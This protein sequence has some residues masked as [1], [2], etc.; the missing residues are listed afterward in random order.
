MSNPTK[1]LATKL[2]W[3]SVLRALNV[4][5][6][7][8]AYL[9]QAVDCT[10]CSEPTLDVMEDHVLGGVW[11]HCR[12]CKFSG[13]AVELAAETWT[14]DVDAAITQL[15][16]LG[17]FP[18]P[19]SDDDVSAYL[20]D[21]VR[22]RK[23]FTDFWERARREPQGGTD[24]DRQLL[25]KFCLENSWQEGWLEQG[26]QFFGVASKSALEELFAPDSFAIQERANR[27]DKKSKRRGPGPGP[28]RILDGH[29]W[30]HLIVVPF[31]DLPGRISGLLM[32]GRNG[33]FDAND[34]VFKRA[35]LGYSSTSPKEAGLG[36]LFSDDCGRA[37]GLGDDVFVMSHAQIGMRL[38]GKH[39]VDSRLPLPVVLVHE[40]HDHT[41][42]HL[43]P[44]LQERRLVFWG[45]MATMLPLAKRHGGCVSD[46]VI[47]ETEIDC[48]LKHNMPIDW[49]RL[50]RQHAK[51]WC[52][53][54]QDYAKT[55]SDLRLGNLLGKLDLTPDESRDLISGLRPDS[56]DQF[57]K[58]EPFRLSLRTVQAKGREVIESEAGWRLKSG[59]VICDKPIRVEYVLTTDNSDSVYRVAVPRGDEQ[60]TFV[61]RERDMKRDGLFVCVSR[62]LRNETGDV[63][64]YQRSWNKDALFI[65]MRF[66]PPETITSSHR[67]GWQMK[68]LRF[69]FPHFSILN[70]GQVQKEPVAIVLDDDDP[71]AQNLN[72]PG[73][74][75]LAH[76]RALSEPSSATQIVWALAACVCHNLLAGTAMPRPCGII[77]DG[78]FAQEAGATAARALGCAECDTTRRRGGKTILSVIVDAAARHAWPPLVKFRQ[79]SQHCF[80]SQWLDEPHL[81]NAILPLDEF[82]ALAVGSHDDF[83]RVC[84]PDPALPLGE[85]RLAAT[86]IVPNYLQDLCVRHKWIEFS[87]GPKVIDV[88]H[89][90][91]E[92]FRRIGGSSASVLNAESALFFDSVQRATT[93]A[94]LATRMHL[95]GEITTARAGFD[96]DWAGAKPAALIYCDADGDKP[97]MVAVRPHEINAVL[98][99]RRAPAMDLE[100]IQSAFQEASAWVGNASDDHG[101]LWLIDAEWWEEKTVELKRQSVAVYEAS[102]RDALLSPT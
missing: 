47:S 14:I 8:P 20:R 34:F 3:E 93:F 9:P 44:S 96:V 11:F 77:L 24:C 69:Q 15:D 26:G 29:G 74:F 102:K 27:N 100:R 4:E 52:C 66:S 61:I 89:D 31:H 62:S 21:H 83:V 85:L 13:D 18:D 75:P 79:R 6:S 97:A 33:D 99:G 45:P 56:V 57:K 51:P 7:R 82:A 88:L 38:Q 92:W 95:G 28:R 40:S 64:N 90:M 23:R 76:I 46:Y 42:F 80:T 58:C 22:Y 54:L 10:L 86:S 36:M 1:S 50:I 37:R 65:A 84:V 2:S 35:N 71:P 39:L 94:E 91:A 48:N 60:S 63:L 59:E 81:R 30:E 19:I 41:L 55:L 98:R 43:P 87:G 12:T 16:V 101:E 73:H 67:I 70:R 53:A 17:L 5:Q 72:P 32:V 25:R 78:E 68:P 49:L